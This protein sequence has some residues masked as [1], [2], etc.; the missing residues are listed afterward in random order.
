[1]KSESHPETRPHPFAGMLPP[2]DPAAHPTGRRAGQCS[3]CGE[4]RNHALHLRE[5]EPE[6][7]DQAIALLGEGIGFTFERFLAEVN[8]LVRRA[9]EPMA[10]ELEETKYQLARALECE[11][12]LGAGAVRLEEERDALLAAEQSVAETEALV[13]SICECGAGPERL[14][15]WHESPPGWD[16]RECGGFVPRA[17]VTGDH[18]P[19]P[20]EDVRAINH[21][22]DQP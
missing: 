3:L 20:G 17:H 5:G 21:G 22:K 2:T 14:S 12:Q 9:T 19:H 15:V 11:E 4:E 18:G 6:R 8:A 13:K 1:M 10:R 16:C 7:T